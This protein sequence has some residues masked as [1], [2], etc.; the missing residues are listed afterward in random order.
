MHSHQQSIA[1][2]N[3]NN[4]QNTEKAAQGAAS[5]SNYSINFI[6]VDDIDVQMPVISR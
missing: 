2:S 1:I 6:I 4:Q 3:I 5:M